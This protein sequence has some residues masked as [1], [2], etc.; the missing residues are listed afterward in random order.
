MRFAGDRP[1][2]PRLFVGANGRVFCLDRDRGDILWERKLTGS[3]FTLGTN[4]VNVAWVDGSLMASA[5]GIIYRLGPDHGEII[6]SRKLKTTA[7]TTYTFAVEPPNNAAAATDQF[8]RGR[9]G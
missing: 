2:A 5:H 6:W 9:D 1:N 3:W 7:N 8:N 4:F